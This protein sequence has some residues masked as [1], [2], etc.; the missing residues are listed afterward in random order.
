MQSV[1]VW[2]TYQLANNWAWILVKIY[3]RNRWVKDEAM[4]NVKKYVKDELIVIKP[5]HVF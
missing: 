3:Y 4:L 5:I 1:I 2:Y